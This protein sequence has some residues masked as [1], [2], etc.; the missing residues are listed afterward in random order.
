[1]VEA[2][3]SGAVDFSRADLC[4]PRWTN[5]LRIV[6]VEVARQSRLRFVSTLHQHY[7]TFATIPNLED[8][9][10]KK[11]REGANNALDLIIQQTEPWN[12]ERVTQAQKDQAK[13]AVEEWEAHYGKLSD[14]AVQAAIDATVESVKRHR[15]EQKL[16][17]QAEEAIWKDKH[18]GTR[19]E[20]HRVTT[21]SRRR[22]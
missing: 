6:L 17:K 21:K 3:A 14:P 20:R 12:K 9:S 16:K 19:R 13:A 22:A 1:M 2:A 7:V 15:I 8:G 18:K 11:L 5:Y 10:F 4:N